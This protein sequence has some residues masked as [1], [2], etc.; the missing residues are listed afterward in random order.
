MDLASHRGSDHNII[1]QSLA[2]SVQA[3]FA[4]LCKLACGAL[5][6]AH[7]MHTQMLVSA[8][9]AAFAALRRLRTSLLEALALQQDAE[10]SHSG[11][12]SS[13]WPAT[14]TTIPAIICPAAAAVHTGWGPA[15][16]AAA[17]VAVPKDDWQVA[18]RRRRGARGSRTSP[19]NTLPAVGAP[20]ARGLPASQLSSKATRILR[21]GDVA[22]LPLLPTLNGWL[23]G[24]PVAYLVCRSAA[25][26]WSVAHC[27]SDVASHSN[28]HNRSSNLKPADPNRK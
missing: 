6:L 1:K 4:E 27:T 23:L 13:P 17:A 5:L 8:S 28:L 21:L 16:C 19:D 9:Q 11:S 20:D 14:A 18:G 10:K 25:V 15:A 2:S 7:R 3:C 12:S 22:G 24:Y 26:R